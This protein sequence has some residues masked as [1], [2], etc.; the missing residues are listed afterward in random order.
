[1]KILH[2]GKYFSPF[3]GGI[4]NMM[5]ALIQQQV[6]LGLSVSALVHH[7]EPARKFSVSKEFGASIYRIPILGK[8]LFVPLAITGLFKYD[9]RQNDENQPNYYV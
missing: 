5:L 2:I 9:Q 6:S 8:L 1:M 3:K 4:E 7:H